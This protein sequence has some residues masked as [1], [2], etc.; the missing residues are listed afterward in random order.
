MASTPQPTADVL[1]L[2]SEFSSCILKASIFIPEKNNCAMSGKTPFLHPSNPAAAA[3]LPSLPNVVL[4]AILLTIMSKWLET[5]AELFGTMRL[6]FVFSKLLV[7]LVFATL[8]AASRWIFW[9]LLI[10]LSMSQWNLKSIMVVNLSLQAL[11]ST[12]HCTSFK[13]AFISFTGLF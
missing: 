6:K 3:A 13:V 7:V 1:F 4:A 2:D 10:C 12:W 8:A 11:H 5:A 9:I